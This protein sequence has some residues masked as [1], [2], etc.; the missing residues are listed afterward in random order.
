MQRPVVQGLGTEIKLTDSTLK[1]SLGNSADLKLSNI[2]DL[3]AV[4]LIGKTPKVI[5]VSISED[6]IYKEND[7]IVLTVVFNE[8]VYVVNK[9]E[10]ISPYIELLLDNDN[11]VKA[12]YSEGSGSECLKF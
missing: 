12:S 4:K 7:S 9:Y 11:K 10:F 3:S 1:S 6:K 5:S 8:K 2:E